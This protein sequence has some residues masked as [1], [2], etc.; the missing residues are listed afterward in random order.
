[1]ITPAA[2]KLF[3][4]GSN[5]RLAALYYR[6]GTVAKDLPRRLVE[7]YNFTQGN[8][9]VMLRCYQIEPDE[10]WRFLMLH[11]IEH[12]TDAGAAFNPRRQVR[13]D[14][15]ELDLT[16]QE[17]PYWTPE[18][19]TYRDLVSDA[20]ADGKVTRE[21][22]LEIEA[23]AMNNGISLQQL[24]FVHANI[25]HRC[26]GAIIEDGEVDADERL[27]LRFLSRVLNVLGWSVTDG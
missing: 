17:R 26:L 6:K 25:F 20:L 27:Q 7:P 12:V 23:Y 24:R 11:K 3:E 9:D 15:G 14:V 10:G 13:L 21:E 4:L 1:M 22:R 8:E 19:Q 18:L 2:K 5:R 16:Y